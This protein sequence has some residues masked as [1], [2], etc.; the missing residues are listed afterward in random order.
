MAFG[1]EYYGNSNPTYKVSSPSLFDGF[2]AQ[3][4]FSQSELN[5]LFQNT[6]DNAN[7]IW[8]REDSAYQRMVS[9]MRK[10]GLNPWT[11]VASGG[12]PTSSVNPAESALNSL[13]SGLNYNLGVMNLSD[14][15]N[16]RLVDTYIDVVKIMAGIASGGLSA[17]G[18]M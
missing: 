18:S 16:A 15:Q 13:F 17:L 1:A 4:V 2:D 5:S 10:A 6:F 9:D 12:S 8:E 3:N 7:K 11:G 14:K